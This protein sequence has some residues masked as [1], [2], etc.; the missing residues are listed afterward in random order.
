M[1]TF[2]FVPGAFHGGW[3]FDRMRPLLEQAG[4]AVF[5]PTLSGVG[6]RAHLASLGNINLETHIEDVARLIEWHDLHDVVLCGH[7]YG[8]MV[9]TGV[10]ERMANRLTALAYIDAALPKD[11]DS[12]FSLL[13]VVVP[14]FIENS[15]A[16]GG[17]LV[18]PL[19]AHHFGCA[20]EHHEWV[21][22]RLTPHPLACFTQ[23]IVLKDAHRAVP[24]RILVYNTSDIGMP[25]P[26]PQWYEAL[27][28]QPGDH[29]F[30][31]AGGHDLMIDSAEELATI[32]LKTI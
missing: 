25:T 32:L 29:V 11:G 1:A 7:S 28:G 3:C 20:P 19:Q 12:Q 15:A 23:A 30:A 22:A 14:V 24:K 13:P 2:V 5:T 18:A 21:N 8:G 26:M 27:R 17:S 9:I 6:E 4:H 16:F 10:A 31:L